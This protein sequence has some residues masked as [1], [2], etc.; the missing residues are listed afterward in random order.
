[1]GKIP[2][3]PILFLRNEVKLLSNKPIN[4]EKVML[5]DDLKIIVNKL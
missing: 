1:M 2:L 5:T 3:Y 4:K